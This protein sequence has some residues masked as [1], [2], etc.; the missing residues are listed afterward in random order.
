M[1]REIKQ[2]AIVLAT[3][4]FVPCTLVVMGFCWTMK[5]IWRG[6]KEIRWFILEYGVFILLVM[7]ILFSLFCL[8]MAISVN[9]TNGLRNKVIPRSEQIQITIAE[10][11]TIKWTELDLSGVLTITSTEG[12]GAAFVIKKL[13]NQRWWSVSTYHIVKTPPFIFVDGC[14]AKI[15]GQD[16]IR[17]VVIL[18]F[19]SD[20]NYPV[21]PLG[22]SRMGEETA[23]VGYPTMTSLFGT[24]DGPVIHAGI[25][26][27][28]QGHRIGFDGGGAPGFSGGPIFNRKGEV[29]GIASSC[30]T[31]WSKPSSILGI[32]VKSQVVQDIL[33]EIKK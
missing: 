8:V 26:S 3:L 21:Y 17:D 33:K 30:F 15:V 25:V 4:F 6:I 20:K 12:S 16:I 5:K 18:E 32:C 1:L 23:I 11:P 9:L 14:L 13:D 2:F 22:I 31:V 29:I 24:I 27:W 10:K 19:S 7:G 28:S